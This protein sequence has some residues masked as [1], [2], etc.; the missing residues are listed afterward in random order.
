M[1]EARNNL[2]EAAKL[3]PEAWA[4]WA[5]PVPGLYRYT[6]EGLEIEWLTGLSEEGAAI[7]ALRD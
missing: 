7:L 1:N 4:D 3:N 6:G 5:R 2:L